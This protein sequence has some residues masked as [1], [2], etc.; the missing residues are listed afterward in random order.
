MKF[1]V[2]AFVATLLSAPSLAAEFTCSGT[3]ATAASRLTSMNVSVHHSEVSG[4]VAL[5][6][7]MTYGSD[8]F[9]HVADG[10]VSVVQTM[11]IHTIDI[12]TEWNRADIISATSDSLRR[13][14][15]FENS[16]ISSSPLLLAINDTR[17]P[18][19]ELFWSEGS[20]I[21]RLTCKRN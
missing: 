2:I 21:A 5:S 8:P 3:V 20:E 12:D 1:P 9:L 4:E 13:V 11:V 17:F 18:S 7:V 6:G 15:R 19:V 14:I 10:R 16:Q